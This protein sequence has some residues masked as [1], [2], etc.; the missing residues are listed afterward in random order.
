MTEMGDNLG[1]LN[2]DTLNLSKGFKELL[3][4]LQPLLKLVPGYK[5]PEETE[6]V[7]A[8]RQ[9]AV[10]EL[11]GADFY[12]KEGFGQGKL[13]NLPLVTSKSTLPHEASGEYD[14]GVV[15]IAEHRRENGPALTAEEKSQTARHELA[16]YK[17]RAVG[18]D[19]G[20]VG[21]P[22]ERK[23]EEELTA[24]QMA[25]EAKRED[26]GDLYDKDLTK[27]KL[28]P[29]GL[30]LLMS[31]KAGIKYADTYA[32]DQSATAYKLALQSN[33]FTLVDEF[34]SAREASGGKAHRS[35]DKYIGLRQEDHQELAENEENKRRQAKAIMR[36]L[37]FGG[38][39]RA[40]GETVMLGETALKVALRAR[41]ASRLASRGATVAEQAVPEGVSVAEAEVAAQQAATIDT[42]ESTAQGANGFERW[43]YG[44]TRPSV[45]KVLTKVFP[46]LRPHSK[47]TGA[48]LAIAA[49]EGH[50][51]KDTTLAPDIDKLNME[52]QTKKVP[53]TVAPVAPEQ[54]AAEAA[55][56]AQVAVSDAAQV[57]A[58]NETVTIEEFYRQN[59]NW[60]GHRENGE[61][62]LA[63]YEIN[64][65]NAYED[66]L[67]AGYDTTNAAGEG[68]HIEAG[69]H[70]PIYEPNVPE[71]D[72]QIDNRGTASVIYGSRRDPF[73]VP[74]KNFGKAS[75]TASG[76]PVA[77]LD[78]TGKIATSGAPMYDLNGQAAPAGKLAQL[79]DQANVQSA[80]IDKFVT[81]A[82]LLK[83]ALDDLT[84]SINKSGTS[85]A[86]GASAGV[87]VQVSAPVSMAVMTNGA[88]ID[89]STLESKI[90]QVCKD[91]F[92]NDFMT[93]LQQSLATGKF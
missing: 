18:W 31:S 81:S 86:S 14:E 26:W 74:G 58:S 90:D 12:E 66:R 67:A 49:A 7:N 61:N 62:V 40:V 64:R 71:Q 3:A 32:Q 33:E 82:D 39:T 5:T 19:R 44:H 30:K 28:K 77:S 92:A 83:K 63:N 42:A 2:G 79:T 73:T 87:S 24:A 38:S 13:K 59:P 23:V 50:F 10:K 53:L 48:A 51:I 68:V 1:E 36:F 8:E 89:E 56:T 88:G 78:E 11:V 43:I 55:V 27:N 93:R 46:I 47:L 4:S 80:F 34:N 70:R 6:K 75:V 54:K 16:H 69:I 91:F 65:K 72:Y 22:I 41:L 45:Q 84:T 21:T 35:L 17:I 37:P 57:A 25:G 76:V 60:I 29:E 15:T 52:A 85:T 20:F 9:K